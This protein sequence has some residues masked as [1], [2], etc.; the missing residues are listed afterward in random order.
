MLYPLLFY[1]ILKEKI[2]GGRRLGELFNRDLLGDRVGESWDV[3]CHENG[4][5]LVANGS[6]KGK[7]LEDLI[8]EYGRGLLGNSLEQR[9][10]DKFPLL[11]KILD[12]RDVLSVQVHPGDEY[13]A[14]HE[15]GELGK[16]EM[17]YVLDAEPGSY[18]YYGVKPGIGAN[19]FKEALE[20]GD[21][22]PYLC[23][24]AVQQGDVLYMPSGMVHAIG[25]GILICEIQQNSDTTYRV[26]D[27]NRLGDD[28]SFRE[29]HIEKALDVIDFEGRHSREKV[30]GIEV[31][32]EGFSRTYLVACPYF[33]S[34]K[35]DL[36]DR[37]TD[38]ANGDKFFILT[39][40]EGQGDIVYKDGS[41]KFQVGN[42]VMIPANLG[43]YSIVG[44]CKIIKTYIPDR[45]KDITEV[46]KKEGFS[47]EDM[48]CIAG[49][50]DE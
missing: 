41:Q 35:L 28:G 4:T 13:A 18:L 42:S 32:Y 19:E 39:I 1:P 20:K 10:I 8:E 43:D 7:S 48:K 17:W 31:K 9:D 14:F 49:L 47:I 16:T 27:W 38:K 50:F 26:F 40:I 25:S 24:M 21:V 5:S 2:W 3:A 34:E 6:H 33:A 22:E 11:I 15:D 36:E 37:M 12:A 44:N 29:L 45:N 46:L 30:K 23:R